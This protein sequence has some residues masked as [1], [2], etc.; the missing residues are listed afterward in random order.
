MKQPLKGNHVTSVRT[1]Q[2]FLN[3]SIQSHYKPEFKGKTITLY[4]SETT[5]QINP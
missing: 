4:P 3:V 1:N 5:V 2:M